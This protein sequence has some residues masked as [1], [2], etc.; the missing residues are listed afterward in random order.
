MD[1]KESCTIYI[2]LAALRRLSLF[3]HVEE[4]TGCC[5]QVIVHGGDCELS[6][7]VEFSRNHHPSNEYNVMPRVGLGERAGL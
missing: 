3:A 5:F 7:D 1:K 4:D 2:P 6:G